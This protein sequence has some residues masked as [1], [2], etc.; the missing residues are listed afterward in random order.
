MGSWILDCDQF[1]KL[2]EEKVKTGDREGAGA[3]YDQL[4]RAW[5]RGASQAI[6]PA[7]RT[8]RMENSLKFRELALN[9][10]SGKS[11]SVKTSADVI[12]AKHKD[13]SSP[14]GSEMPASSM[15]NI[16]AQL[17]NDS[18]GQMIIGM[19]DGFAQASTVTWSDIGG[20][21]CL[22][23]DLKRAL[24]SAVVKYPENVHREASGDILLYGPPGTGKTLLAAA[25]ASA[26]KLD[27][28]KGFFYNVRAAGLKGHYQ[29]NT[30]KSISLLYE[31]AGN[32][33]PS[34][35]FVDEIDG[36]CTSRDGAQ[37]AASRAILSVLLEEMDGMS[38]KGRSLQER[39]VLTV[40]ATNTPWA[41]DAALLSRFGE[42]RVYVPAP[43]SNGRLQILGKQMKGYEP[44]DPSVLEWLAQDEQ[45]E[46]Y[47]GRD[48][49]S[50]A[51]VAKNRMEIE[52]NQDLADWN[53]LKDI[54][55]KTVKLRPLTKEDFK[56]ALKQV[57]ASITPKIIEHYQRWSE[58]PTY[59]PR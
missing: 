54:M 55:D 12:V 34:L 13:S 7:E 26:L 20:L 18:I 9:H 45:T 37:D 11:E 52:L 3:A 36:I 29:G 22:V 56:T 53:D 16:R 38:K 31:T 8:I 35:V 21:D 5:L 2:A 33:S 47:S 49:R 4:S 58:D 46:G 10:I 14:S 51:S 39:F 30:E 1:R 15:G 23:K 17:L 6:S 19:V 59:R 57:P 27:G 40:A 32:T 24:A 44:E 50:L 25:L 28:G 43:D 48:L 42:N 41:L